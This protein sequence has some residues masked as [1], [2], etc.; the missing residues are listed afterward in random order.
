MIQGSINLSVPVPPSPL[1]LPARPPLRVKL[2]RWRPKSACR[3]CADLQRG[4]RAGLRG[5]RVGLRGQREAQNT[6]GGRPPRRHFALHATPPGMTAEGHPLSGPPPRVRR[7][8]SSWSRR[9][10]PTG[11]RR[12]PPPSSLPRRPP[13]APPCLLLLLLPS[14]L[15]SLSVSAPACAPVC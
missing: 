1:P 6:Q 8:R 7:T 15:A 11:C 10:A 9:S 4:G 13:A 14:A 12:P 5:A 3:W 2:Q